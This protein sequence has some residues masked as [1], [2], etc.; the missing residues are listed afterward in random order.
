MRILVSGENVLVWLE[1]LEIGLDFNIFVHGFQ[2]L[3]EVEIRGSQGKSLGVLLEVLQ[4]SEIESFVETLFEVE[5]V[6][7]QEVQATKL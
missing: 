6:L 3:S 5:V 1:S 7:G 4:P 2:M